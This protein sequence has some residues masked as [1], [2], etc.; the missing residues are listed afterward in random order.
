MAACR[1]N[2]GLFYKQGRGGLP[3]DDRQA[4]RLYKLA[5]DQRNAFA[6]VNLGF[7]PRRGQWRSAEGRSPSR[8]FLQARCRPGKRGRA[9]QSRSLVRPGPGRPAEGVPGSRPALQA[10]RR[11]REMRTRRPLLQNVARKT[12]KKKNARGKLPTERVKG[13]NSIVSTIR[14]PDI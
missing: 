3:K 5:A 11:P 6:Q 12:N 2:I 4:A 8:A 14:R 13:R 10:R 9:I 1:F 7:L